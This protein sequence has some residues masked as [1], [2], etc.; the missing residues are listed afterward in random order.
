[1]AGGRAASFEQEICLDRKILDGGGRLAVVELGFEQVEACGRKG[2][3]AA[4]KLCA[5]LDFG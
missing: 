5:M 4:S 1:M 2:Q 3:L